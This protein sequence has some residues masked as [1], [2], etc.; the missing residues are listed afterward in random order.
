MNRCDVQRSFAEPEAWKL[1]RKYVDLGKQT[2]SVR[3]KQ[4]L[5]VYFGGRKSSWLLRIR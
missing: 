1:L 3:A 2:G 5:V 4:G